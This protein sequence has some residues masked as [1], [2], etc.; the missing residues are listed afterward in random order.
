[1]NNTIPVS[2]II[3]TYNR[4]ASLQ[5][6]I[7]ALESQTKEPDKF[8]V[9]VIS[10]G[11][12]DGTNEYLTQYENGVCLR[13]I[14]QK[15]TGPAG[16]R[17]QGVQLAVGDLLLFLDDDV[18]PTPNFI[19]E[20]VAAH[21]KHYWEKVVV[22]GPMLTPTD[23]SLSPWSKW[24][25]NRLLEQ[26]QSMSNGEWEPAARQF[27]TGNASLSR[28]LFLDHGGF[29]T[30][31]LRAEDVELAY[32]M[33]GAGVRF[34]FN[35]QATGFHY[36][37][38]EFTSWLNI[39]YSYGQNDVIFYQQKGVK[40]LL[41]QIYTEFT[42]RPVYIQLLVSLSLDRKSL[43]NILTR[44]GRSL[45]FRTERMMPGDLSRLGCSMLFNLYYYQ[46][47]ADKLGGREHFF[48]F[49]SFE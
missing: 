43:M 20:H 38:R 35:P 36:E 26:Y 39:A 15:N 45:I 41:P 29:D 48:A 5:T 10:D 4:L 49:K 2:V 34:I 19:T 14:F 7:K 23:F 8:E 31:F 9:I 27:Y 3:P 37:R 17:N 11:S 30:S 32:R 42:Q 28:Q 21:N 12:T 13:P 25:Q 33:A 16:A 47:I 44:L 22:L 24:M 1:M 18:V 40:W 46:G 6:V